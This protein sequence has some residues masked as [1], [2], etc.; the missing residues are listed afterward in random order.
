[1][2]PNPEADYERRGTPMLVLG[3]AAETFSQLSSSP[4]SSC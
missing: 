4:L 3:A 2:G 1:M